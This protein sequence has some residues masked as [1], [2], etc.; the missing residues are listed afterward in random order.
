V[1]LSSPKQPRKQRQHVGEERTSPKRPAR[2]ANGPQTGHAAR[3][4]CIAA[5]GSAYDRSF[6]N[7]MR[8]T[9]PPCPGHASRSSAHIG[10][11]PLQRPGF[12]R[13]RAHPYV[14]LFG[15]REDRRHRLRMDRLDDGIR[16]CRQEAVDLMRSRY[17]LR[18][19]PSITVR[20]RW[21]KP[22]TT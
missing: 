2:S 14:A 9:C 22:A 12:V 20:T 1:V 18:S 7:F 8:L 21:R 17:G 4:F 16:C 19:G 5:F 6:L 3:K 15:G 10:Q 11:R 13:G